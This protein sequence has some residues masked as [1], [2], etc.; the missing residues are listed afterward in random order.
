MVVG[1][2]PYGDTTVASAAASFLSTVAH[3]VTLTGDGTTAAPLAVANNGVGT[4]QLAN[5]SVTSAKIASAQ[6]V[7][8]VNGL[9]DNIVLAAGSNVSI[10]LT[11]NT[12]TIA[13]LL[14][15]TSVAHDSTL[16]GAGTSASPL[17][18]ANSGVGSSQLTDGA[19]TAP[20][21]ASGQVVRSLNG[22]TDDVELIAGSN[23]T[24][25]PSG[26]NVT[27]N[28]FPQPYINPLRVA[29]LQWYE[30]NQT[31][32]Q[33]PIGSAGTQ[34]AFDGTN[35]WISRATFGAVSKVRV[36]DGTLVGKYPVS[37]GE[38]QGVAFDGANIWV[39][40]GDFSRNLTKIRAS[41]A[42]ILGGVTLE[43]DPFGL[44]FDGANIWATNGPNSVTKVRA[45][46][47]VIL[48]TFNAGQ[49]PL[50]I[51]FDG[52][53]V[54]I[55]NSIGNTVTKI[56]ASDGATLG[57]FNVA[58]SP[59]GIAFDGTNVWVTHPE[60]NLLTKLRASDGATLGTFAIGGFPVGI[61]FDGAHIWVSSRNAST[62]TKLRTIDDVIIGT[63][64]VVGNPSALAFDGANVWAVTGVTVSKL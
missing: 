16:T 26:N 63:F 58:A 21:I 54:W 51:A 48:G 15:L 53:N 25:T 5:N 38:T 57:T 6:V 59:F 45:T 19:V 8:S 47:G 17:G 41:D 13:T 37:G 14:G 22:L 27:V 36:S 56:R 12:L 52:A 30:L 42:T 11:G 3:D 40:V 4:N 32:L 44:A 31:G 18:I 50:N 7:K 60:A 39:A 10:D 24:I 43:A 29:T 55:T 33:Y 46:D 35:M 23:I 20:K 9:T 49:N 1:N 64:T 62:V 2:L 34:I 28:A 61:V